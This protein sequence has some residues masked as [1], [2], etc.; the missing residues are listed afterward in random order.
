MASGSIV[1]NTARYGPD[2]SNVAHSMSPA[3]RRNAAPATGTAPALLRPGT[4]S[5][6]RPAPTSTIDVDHRCNRR[7]PSRTNSVSSNPERLRFTDPVRVVIDER[8]AVGHHRVVDGVPVAAQLDRHLV[9]RA[10]VPA[11]LH[12]DPPP[13][14][15]RQRQPRRRDR[16]VLAVHDPTGH[17]ACTHTQRCLCHTSRAG[18][19][20]TGRSTSS[21]AVGPFTTAPAQPAH[22]RPRIAGLDM[23]HA[24]APALSIDAEH[25]HLRQTNQQ[26]AHARRVHFHRG[27]PELDDVRHRQV[28]RAPVPR[29]GP[30]HPAHFRSA[31]KPLRIPLGR[32]F[33]RT[34]NPASDTSISVPS[35]P[36]GTTT[37]FLTGSSAGTLPRLGSTRDKAGPL[38]LDTLLEVPTPMST[39]IEQQRTTGRPSRGVVDVGQCIRRVANAMPNLW[40]SDTASFA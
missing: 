31:G 20:N 27:S 6:S 19:P 10:P 30:L 13:R 36:T 1:S 4:T 17:A 34:A 32:P 25:G 33:A 40:T 9:H 39:P 37:Y 38:E 21:T 11:D 24:R 12:G 22:T 7:G 18:R 26:L 35:P 2:R 14:P 16:R 8:R 28:R 3:R 23:H 29:Q 5:N 15:I